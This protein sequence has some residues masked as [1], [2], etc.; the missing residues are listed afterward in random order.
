[1]ACQDPIFIDV[2]NLHD[3]Y[4]YNDAYDTDDIIGSGA[5]GDVYKVTKKENNRIY[6]LKIMGG[7]DAD[8]S[9]IGN[10]NLLLSSKKMYKSEISVGLYIKN[11]TTLHK[12]VATPNIAYKIK[13]KNSNIGYYYAIEYNYIN[14]TTISYYM[15]DQR[16]LDTFHTMYQTIINNMYRIYSIINILHNNNIVHNDISPNNIMVNNDKFILIDFGVACNIQCKKSENNYCNYLGDIRYVHPKLIN[17]ND[18]I[19]IIERFNQDI[20]AL[21]KSFYDSFMNKTHNIRLNSILKDLYT[22]I[23]I[24]DLNNLNKSKINDIFYQHIDKDVLL[25]TTILSIENMN[26][27]I[28][29]LTSINSLLN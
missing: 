2:E 1:M 14:G 13:P 8:Y 15:Y 6:A 26:I 27:S 5:F 18:N 12:Y 28:A 10:L 21:I 4:E 24:D 20:Y 16:G 9:D 29:D 23:N 19:T 17:K 22:Q 7:L 11:N 3:I 25:E